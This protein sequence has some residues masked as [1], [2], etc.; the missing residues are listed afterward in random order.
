MRNYAR[1][2]SYFDL[3][4]SEVYPEPGSKL[5]DNITE[6]V[7]ETF[8]A[9]NAAHIK[10]ALDVGCG[11]G[12]ALGRFKSLGI[13][14]IGITLGDEDREQCLKAGYLVKKMDQS[15]LDFPN[16]HFHLVYAR[17]VLEHSP[18]PLFTLFEFN[19]VLKENAY[20]YIEVPW[21]ESVHAKNPN[22]YS[23]LGKMSWLHLFKKARFSVLKDVV[24]D[25]KLTDGT[26]DQYWGWWLQKS[27]DIPL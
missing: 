15:F 25:F 1:I 2:E 7:F 9:P 6:Q 27:S 18:L 13:E 24:V 8:I 12:P 4:E 21:A 20:A 19:R 22:H 23:I 16:C 26:P 17:H 5:H 10:S 14:A 3:L 11:Q